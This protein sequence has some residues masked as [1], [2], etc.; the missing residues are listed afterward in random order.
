MWVIELLITVVLT[1]Q[2]WTVARR[3]CPL[4]NC[5]DW[6]QFLLPEKCQVLLIPLPIALGPTRSSLRLFP[7]SPKPSTAKA[8][9]LNPLPSASSL[10][11]HCLTLLHVANG[12]TIVLTVYFAFIVFLK[13]RILDHV[14]QFTSEFWRTSVSSG[15]WWSYTLDTILKR[16]Y[17]EDKPEPGECPLWCVFTQ[18]P[19]SWDHSWFGLT[20]PTTRYSPPPWGYLP[21]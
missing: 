17:G 20:M 11:I 18:H 13:D 14:P 7:S 5:L 10:D 19:V 1:Q 16:S 9:L 4:V 3:V 15:H 21:S 6:T 2:E 12:N 8:G